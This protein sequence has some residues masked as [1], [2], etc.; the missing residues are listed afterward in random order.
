MTNEPLLHG[1]IIW[2]SLNEYTETVYTNENKI[3]YETRTTLNDSFRTIKIYIK[4]FDN[5]GQISQNDLQDF[6]LDKEQNTQ[7]YKTTHLKDNSTEISNYEYLDMDK[8]H[9]PIKLLITKKSKGT[10][11]LVTIDYTFY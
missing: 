10:K 7:L 8:L 11:T 1:K 4:G 9:N 5:L 6:Q 2:K 3:K